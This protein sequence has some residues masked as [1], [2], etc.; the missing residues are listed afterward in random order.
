M[1]DEEAER[2]DVDDIEEDTEDVDEHEEELEAAAQVEP[3]RAPRPMPQRAAE[4]PSLESLTISSETKSS[5]ES[6][7]GSQERDTRL[8]SRVRSLRAEDL[9]KMRGLADRVYQEGWGHLSSEEQ[10]AFLYHSRFLEY[11]SGAERE[12]EEVRSTMYRFVEAQGKTI[13]LQASYAPREL[14]MITERFFGQ[15]ATPFNR[16]DM[17]RAPADTDTYKR[18]EPEP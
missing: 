1:S 6:D 13:G 9:Q 16:P 5:E 4:T 7:E 17:Y 12:R 18:A 15:I 14:P 10:Q 8:E 2:K 11:L 3:P